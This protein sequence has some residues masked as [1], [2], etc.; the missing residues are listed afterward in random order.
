M[1]HDCTVSQLVARRVAQAREIGIDGIV[2]SP[3]EARAIRNLAGPD[4]ILVTPGVRSRGTAQGDQKRVATP[5]DAIRDGSDYLV[6]GRQVTRAADPV[7]ALSAIREELWVP[8]QAVVS[9][10]MHH[11]DQFLANYGYFALFGLLMLGIVGP[12]IPDE[13]ILIFA[14]IAIHSGQMQPVP[15]L[16][17]AIAGSLCGINMSYML[18]RTGVEFTRLK[19]IPCCSGA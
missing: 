2:A 12:L 9:A 15:T 8:E 7:A 18:G 3:L 17:V 5:A 1:G 10:P 14:G 11:V 19:R 16:L 4:A 6:I 13:T